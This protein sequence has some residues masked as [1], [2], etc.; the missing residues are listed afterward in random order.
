MVSMQITSN[1]PGMK[2]PE[3]EIC[4]LMKS[5]IGVIFLHHNINPIV[6]NNLRSIEFHNPDAFVTTI[7]AEDPFPGGYS[8]S[9]TPE[10][11]KYHNVNRRRASDILVC[12]WFLQNKSHC[13]K[14]WIVEW[15]THCTIPIKQYY[16]PVWSYDFVCAAVYLQRRERDWPWFACIRNL[17]VQYRRFATGAVPFLYL[18]SSEALRGV[19]QSM[20]QQPFTA[21]NGELRFA[22]VASKC[23]YPPCGFSPPNDQI[24]WFSPKERYIGKGIYHPV[25]HLVEVQS[26]SPP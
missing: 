15:D 19:C 23:G 16:E 11:Q 17:P 14:W 4:V 7:S 8:L 20:L 18:V 24:S 3:G 26:V 10:L 22:T 21:G 13:D 1:T 6:V 25:K 9:T 5:E 2:L 12:S